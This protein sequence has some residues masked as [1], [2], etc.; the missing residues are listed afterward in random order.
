MKTK[1]SKGKKFISW[2]TEGATK[3]K[4]RAVIR[5]KNTAVRAKLAKKHSDMKLG[6]TLAA[7]KVR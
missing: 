4:E 5:L 6:E 2:H 1:Y 7:M 3:S